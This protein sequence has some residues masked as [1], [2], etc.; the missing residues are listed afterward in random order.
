MIQER[1]SRNR[2]ILLVIFSLFLLCGIAYLLWPEK[3]DDAKT[4][5][6]E[7]NM[8]VKG[9]F[10]NTKLESAVIR[11]LL[12]EER[13]SSETKENSFRFC[14]IENLFPGNEIFP[15]YIWAY[16]GEYIVEGSKLVSLSGL[17][18]PVKINY[19]NELSFYTLDRFSYEIPRDGSEYSK[20]L[21]E[22]LPE[23]F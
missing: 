6:K 7:S 2:K 1:K 11:Y 22:I 21:K 15:I 12:T 8:V 18:G 4:V 10:Q 19:P 23:H 14:A 3:L 17:S 13:F 5:E 20:D 16:C 9:N